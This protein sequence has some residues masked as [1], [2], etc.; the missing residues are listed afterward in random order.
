MAVPWL[1]PWD[2]LAAAVIRIL[3]TRQQRQCYRSWSYL[4]V[5]LDEE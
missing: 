2:V 4:V 5:E 3:I 1:S